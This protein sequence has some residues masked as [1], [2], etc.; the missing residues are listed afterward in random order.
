MASTPLSKAVQF[1]EEFGFYDVV[2]PFLLVFTIVFAV[3]EKTKIF[4]TETVKGE[5]IAKKNINAM[6]AFV[7]ALFFVTAKELVAGVRELLPIVAVLLV[8]LLSFMMLVGFFYS[9]NEFS[10]EKHTAMKILLTIIFLIGITLL[11]WRAFSRKTFNWFF[12]ETTSFWTST[13]GVTIIFL[14][15]IIGTILFVTLGGKK[16]GE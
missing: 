13:G 2:L 7:V 1:L 5:K 6:I 14:G 11:A 4:G 3:L 9:D 15:I 8:T 12:L 16:G 10:F